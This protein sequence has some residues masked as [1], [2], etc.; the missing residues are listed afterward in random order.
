MF[1]FSHSRLDYTALSRIGGGRDFFLNKYCRGVRRP[2]RLR[3]YTVNRSSFI[4]CCLAFTSA[5]VADGRPLSITETS[6]GG[7]V[8]PCPTLIRG[9]FPL[10][11]GGLYCVGR[12][13]IMKARWWGTQLVCKERQSSFSLVWETIY[14]CSQVCLVRTREEGR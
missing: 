2:Y 1:Q 10:T 5:H 6:G 13:G 8:L 4:Y 7:S 11:V 9:C 3:G 14:L 12:P